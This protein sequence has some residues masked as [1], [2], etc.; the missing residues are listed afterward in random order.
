MYVLIEN[1]LLRVIRVKFSDVNITVLSC[2]ELFCSI[3]TQIEIF[4]S[5]FFWTFPAAALPLNIRR[6]SNLG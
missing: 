1:F 6:T 5:L 3:T 2:S 4:G